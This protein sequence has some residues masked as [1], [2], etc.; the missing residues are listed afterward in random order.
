MA[1]GKSNQ[2]M[3][4]TEKNIK[5]FRTA[6]RYLL[7][8]FMQRALLFA[9]LSG[10]PQAAALPPANAA[11]AEY[12]RKSLNRS[13]IRPEHSPDADR[14]QEENFSKSEDIKWGLRRSFKNSDSKYYQQICYGYT[15]DQYGKHIIHEK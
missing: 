2:A 11:F 12:A 10:E 3:I 9:H 15:H 14:A 4:G 5:F 1:G 7:S 8:A 13:T 6:E